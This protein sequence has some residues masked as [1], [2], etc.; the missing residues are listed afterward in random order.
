[1]TASV[2]Q[3]K[4]SNASPTKRPIHHAR[5]VKE[6]VLCTVSG[7]MSGFKRKNLGGPVGSDEYMS[8]LV[9][10]AEHYFNLLDSNLATKDDPYVNLSFDAMRSEFRG[11]LPCVFLDLLCQRILSIAFKLTNNDDIQSVD[12][13]SGS[14]Y[15]QFMLVIYKQFEIEWSAIETEFTAQ[16]ITALIGCMSRG[17]SMQTKCCNK[18]NDTIPAGTKRF[19]IMPSSTESSDNKSDIKNDGRKKKPMTCDIKFGFVPPPVKN[20][21]TT[22]ETAPDKM[23]PVDGPIDNTDQSSKSNICSVC[24][25][26]TKRVLACAQCEQRKYCSKPCQRSDWP[27]HKLNCHKKPQ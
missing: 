22:T 1:M 25:P 19:T 12:V 20:V 10:N 8:R 18:N 27:T 3:P 15:E 23:A 9:G 14:T 11:L 6:F 5:N 21:A 26:T 7:W 17:L 24:G 4:T 13:A 2:T 16:V